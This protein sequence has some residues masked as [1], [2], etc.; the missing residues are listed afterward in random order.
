MRFLPQVGKRVRHNQRNLPP[1]KED[2]LV[3]GAQQRKG[4][5]CRP[6]IRRSRAPAAC[7]MSDGAPPAILHLIESLGSG[8]TERQLVQLIARSS[9][10]ARHLVVTW[11]DPNDLSDQLPRPPLR[12][13]PGPRSRQ[14]PGSL[15]GA[16]AAVRRTVRD[17]KVRLVHAHLSKAE[18]LAAL[19]VPP[20]VPIVASRRGRNDHDDRL[21][22]RVAESVSHRR[23]ACML[24]N[25]EQLASFTLRH[26]SSP[27]PLVVIPN[28]VDVEHFEMS[29]LPRHPNITFVANLRRVKRHDLFLRAL[30]IARRDRPD[31]RATLVGDGPERPRLMAL[32]S[33]LGLLPV[34]RF[35]GQVPDVRPYLRRTRVVVLTSEREGM[36]NALL[37]AMAM[38]RLVVSTAVGGVPELVDHGREGWLTTSVPSDIAVAL[39]LA[40]DPNPAHENVARAARRRAEEHSWTSVVRRTEEVYDQV[41]QGKRFP[42]GRRVD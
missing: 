13:S 38:G 1:A 6:S 21:W 23:V 15:L 10:P 19:A 5:G 40:L 26:D 32:A 42:R 16:M 36:P 14:G 18:L 11:S 31:L 22:F 9:A 12:A 3:R 30:A 28:A 34:I 41:A 2:P 8:G 37:E 4:P 17:H 20:H 24:C 25:S 27:P 29:P 33:Q 39:V 35:V 7:A